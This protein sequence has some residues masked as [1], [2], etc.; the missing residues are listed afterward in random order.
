[1]SSDGRSI[2]RVT[3]EVPGSK[4]I[5]QRA[6]IAAALAKGESRLQNAL[7]AED[8]HYLMKALELLGAKISIEE[9]EIRIAGTGGWIQAPV[10]KIFLG[11]N[12]TALRFLTTLVCLG[13]GIFLLDGTPRLRERPVLPLLQ[14]LRCMGVTIETPEN[15]GCPPLM[16]KARGL[17]GGR[18]VF[19]DLDSSQY[20]S[21]LL[22]SSP[23]AAR[24]VKIRL[25]GRTVSEPYINM[26]LQVM[27]Q[28]GVA[29]ERQKDNI[30]FV[31]AGQS[32][33]ARSFVIEGDYSSAS[34]FFLAA[35]LGL[36]RV[37]VPNLTGE[38][39]QGDARFLRIIEDLGCTVTW[40]DGGVEVAGG[41]LNPG[42]VELA[43]GDIPDMVPSLAVLAV[44]RSGRTVITGASH[45]RIKES[46]RLAA[47]A[48]ELGRIGIAAR[49]TADG[50]IIDGGDP[51]GGD[52]E[53]YDDHR[54]AMSFAIAGLAIPGIRIADRGCVR[55]S[56][57]GFWEEL[58][59]LEPG[60]R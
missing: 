29:V 26:T 41:K 54:I 1:M 43:M 30:F 51:H 7:L 19:T 39:V 14:V 22:L 32:Y 6:L 44:F 49:E 47:L 55:K 60:T 36:A 24:D 28:F 3:L 5:T 40:R 33:T 57:P 56:F 37:C 45:L 53:S 23:Y 50:L 9:K 38:S 31:P 58:K 27:E 35:A 2:R 59:K 25:A 10:E 13:E 15:S 11:N 48:A 4:S 8:T 21:S 34:Y 20:V 12:G 42:D 16:I 52:I 18:T 17:P 46:N